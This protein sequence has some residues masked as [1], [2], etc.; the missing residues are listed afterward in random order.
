MKFVYYFLILFFSVLLFVEI[1]NS[2]NN[3]YLRKNIPLKIEGLENN[4]TKQNKQNK[5]KEESYKPYNFNSPNGALILSQQNAGNIDYLKIR[6]DELNEMK[7]RVDQIQLD[8]DSMQTQ[9]DSLVEQ[10]QQLGNDLVGTNEVEV[11][12]TEE[13]TTDNIE[14]DIQE[15]EMM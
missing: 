3:Y 9:I 5:N 7:G 11:S 12:G 13:M 14:N 10:Q 4:N 6:V 2:F 8:M 15:G 1:I